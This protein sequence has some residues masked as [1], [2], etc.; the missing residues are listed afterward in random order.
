MHEPSKGGRPP[1]L[2][3]T[4][5]KRDTTGRSSAARHPDRE[6]DAHFL[7]PRCPF[8]KPSGLTRKAQLLRTLLV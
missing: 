4:V 6:D 3:R 1:G 2:D 7:G 8:C 5:L